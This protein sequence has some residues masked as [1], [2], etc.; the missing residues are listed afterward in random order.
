GLLQAKHSVRDR[1]APGQREGTLRSVQ[2]NC[3]HG[4]GNHA[5]GAIEEVTEGRLAYARYCNCLS[6][7]E[8]G[9]RI[10]SFRGKRRNGQIGR[11]CRRTA[12]GAMYCG[13]H[14]DQCRLVYSE[15]GMNTSKR[16]PRGAAVPNIVSFLHQIVPSHIAQLAI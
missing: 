2:W 16:A 7:I 6:A 3:K 5:D 11:R 4:R 9:E 8:E 13:R 14:A 15:R 12:P 1:H 10:R